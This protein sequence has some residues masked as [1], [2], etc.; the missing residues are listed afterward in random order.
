M[1]EVLSHARKEDA[2][3]HFLATHWEELIDHYNVTYS[4]YIRGFSFNK[5]KSEIQDYVHDSIQRTN[6]LLGDIILKTLTVPS[7]FAV[8]MIVLRSSK[9]D[10]F[11]N[12]G[13]CIVLT[14]SAVMIIFVVDNQQFLVEQ[15]SKSTMK[16][17]SIFSNR[18]SISGLADKDTMNAL[19]DFITDNQSTIEQRLEYVSIRLMVVRMLI[20]SFV[21]TAFAIT[22]N[23]SWPYSTSIWF[24]YAPLILFLTASTIHILVT[25]IKGKLNQKKNRQNFHVN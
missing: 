22:I 15:I 4:L 12:F 8:W 7:L 16:T 19:D 1:W 9:Y 5:F 23:A 14:L 3:I 24:V 6:N 11:F 13:L 20:W 18:P 2:E 21:L 10:D 25:L 17:M